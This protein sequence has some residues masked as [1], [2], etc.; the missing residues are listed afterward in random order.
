MNELLES[1]ESSIQKRVA[2][3]FPAEKVSFTS[4]LQKML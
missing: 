4:H 2:F 1:N 3:A